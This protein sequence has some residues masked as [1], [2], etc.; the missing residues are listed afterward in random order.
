[1]A[2]RRKRAGTR[3][4]PVSI[5][6]HRTGA[7]PESSGPKSIRRR[8]RRTATAA[9]NGVASA[10]R[11]GA[12]AARQALKAEPTRAAVGLVVGNV[13]AK[14]AGDMI[15][16]SALKTPGGSAAK[17]EAGLNL[18]VSA[19]AAVVG[20]AAALMSG[21]TKKGEVARYV[22]HTAENAASHSLG[23]ANAIARQNKKPVPI[24]TTSGDD[25]PFGTDGGDTG[26]PRRQRVAAR[27]KAIASR[28]AQAMRKEDPSGAGTEGPELEG[29]LEG[30]LEDVSGE[31]EGAEEAIAET[32][33][34][35]LAAAA[36]LSNPETVKA[37]ARLIKLRLDKREIEDVK[38]EQA[39]GAVPVT[40][41]VLEL[42]GYAPED[43]SV[44]TGISEARQLRKEHRQL[45]REA[46]QLKRQD[47][48]ANRKDRR[49]AR[50]E[51]RIVRLDQK[52]EPLRVK[53]DEGRERAQAR[54]E[55]RPLV[56]QT[57]RRSAAAQLPEEDEEGSEE[58]PIIVIP[59][60]D[61]VA[62][63]GA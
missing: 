62:E 39:T 19:G 47:R 10:A 55:Q 11:K 60:D 46:R 37:L 58:L 27:R 45:K 2:R 31:I 32:G 48:R 44:E 26:A 18:A 57:V 56:I 17:H 25:D 40:M 12:A 14:V 21:G 20:I 54:R 15:H 35:P 49:A 7:A 51:A 28:V 53:V 23:A 8:Y 52:N 9:V 4:K 29:Y 63:Y 5:T 30:L 22:V 41:A 59:S 38:A 36:A 34:L 13:A 16:E 61:E 50:K 33:V 6:V 3:R 42:E 43:M 24:P 1:M